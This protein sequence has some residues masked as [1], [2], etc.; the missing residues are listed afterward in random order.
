MDL[1]TNL[2]INATIFYQFGIFLIA[3]L[4]LNQFIFTPYIKAFEEREARTSGQTKAAEDSI[5]ET[6]QLRDEYARL[7][8][9]QME[10]TQAIFAAAKKEAS[11]QYQETLERA[12]AV[13]RQE[14]DKNRM[15][16]SNQ[17]EVAKARIA[18]EAR[19]LSA[20]IAEKIVGREL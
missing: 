10:Q 17:V 4:A 16:I 9:Q 20:V 2:G 1:I 3:Y 18:E 7:L 12:K 14:L 5:G 11:L 19:M 15:E 6:Q 8:R 13:S